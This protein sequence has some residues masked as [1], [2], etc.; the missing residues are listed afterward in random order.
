MRHNHG[1]AGMI[2]MIVTGMIPDVDG[3]DDHDD[4][5]RE[6][7][8]HENAA[9]AEL[10]SKAGPEDLQGFFGT[11]GLGCRILFRLRFGG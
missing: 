9:D 7:A 3:D 4:D 1:D 2:V 5:D 8:A 6:A 10:Q 11:W